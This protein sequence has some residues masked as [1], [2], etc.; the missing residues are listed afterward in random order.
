MSSRKC[1]RPG[2][3]LLELVVVVV[4]LAALAALVIPLVSTSVS[5][6]QE[7]TTRAS[8][9][10]L[11]DV[12][13]NRYWPELNAVMAG[14]DGYPQPNPSNSGGRVLHPQL[15]FLFVSP[16]GCPAYDPISHL[17]W[18]GPYLLHSGGRYK[19]TGSFTTTFGVADDPTVLDGW[20]RPIVLQ[21]PTSGSV[22]E[23]SL[24]TRLVSAGTDGIIQTPASDLMPARSACGDDLVLFLRTADLRP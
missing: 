21:R 12:I 8:M 22:A 7:D 2:L 16:A 9:R 11:Q 24:C 5:Q 23:Q 18:H 14:A 17:G 19:V 6:S 10:E 4:V 20:G 1:R 15:A 3:T 13:I